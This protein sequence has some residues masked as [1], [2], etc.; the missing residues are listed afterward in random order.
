M[1]GLESEKLMNF[2]RS[3][4]FEVAVIIDYP[5]AASV[6]EI[7]AILTSGLARLNKT[8]AVIEGSPG[9]LQKTRSRSEQTAKILSQTG[10][11]LLVYDK[12]LNTIVREA[13]NLGVPVRTI[14]R[15]FDEL[16]GGSRTIRRFLDGA[17][18]RARQEGLKSA[19]VVTASLHPETL[20][21]LL[22]WSMQSRSQT[23][24]IAP[25]SQALMLEN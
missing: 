24:T 14:Y 19:I 18:F 4:G 3:N 10:H 1:T 20:N 17:A 22:L 25:L 16:K 21:A 11:G 2:Y 8:V 6:Q 15:N 23:V 7:D 12:G 9:N 13:E 5:N